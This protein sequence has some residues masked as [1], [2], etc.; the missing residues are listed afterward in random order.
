MKTAAIGFVRVV[1]SEHVGRREQ[2]IPGRMRFG[3]TTVPRAAYRL[4]V[5]PY[6]GLREQVEGA[7]RE[8][9]IEHRLRIGREFEVASVGG[10]IG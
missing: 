5:R 7:M 9:G 6:L 10:E 8:I 1:I 4:F 3:R 2:N